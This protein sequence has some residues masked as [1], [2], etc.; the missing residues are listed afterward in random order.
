MKKYILMLFP[1]ALV[2]LFGPKVINKYWFPPSIQK[3]LLSHEFE[4]GDCIAARRVWGVNPKKVI[5]IKYKHNESY[6]LLKDEDRYE[7]LQL[8]SK[9]E[10]ERFASKIVCR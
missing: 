2:Y 6:Y 7:Q 3:F 10:V 9:G 8:M 4:A 5:G 1:I